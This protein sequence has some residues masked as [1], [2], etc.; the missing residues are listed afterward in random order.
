MA[1]YFWIL[2]VKSVSFC[3]KFGFE[4]NVAMQPTSPLELVP[5]REA[6]KIKE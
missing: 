3:E 4:P 1:S 5:T 2:V 6:R